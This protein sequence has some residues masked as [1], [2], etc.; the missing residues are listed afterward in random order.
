M[1]HEKNERKLLRRELELEKSGQRYM[2]FLGHKTRSKTKR[3]NTIF[4][5]NG[6]ICVIS[7]PHRKGGLE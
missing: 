2:R 7:H 1:K 6:V 5:Q 4:I 3:N